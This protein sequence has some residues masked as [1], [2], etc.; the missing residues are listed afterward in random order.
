MKIRR[1]EGRRNVQ[2]G[3]VVITELPG[4]RFNPEGRVLGFLETPV[5][6]NLWEI[7]EDYT[8]GHIEDELGVEYVQVWPLE[9][10]GA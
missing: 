5:G 8:L 1:P 9:R 2:M 7:G 4:H 10:W 3:P 6:L